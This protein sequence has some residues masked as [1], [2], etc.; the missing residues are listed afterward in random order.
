MVSP[1]LALVNFQKWVNQG[2]SD[3]KNELESKRTKEQCWLIVTKKESIFI[4]YKAQV[5]NFDRRL[6]M[7]SRTRE[8]NEID[9]SAVQMYLIMGWTKTSY[10]FYIASNVL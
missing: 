6:N 5:K 4:I 7:H 1:V 8:V 10:C 9:L 3:L 2:S